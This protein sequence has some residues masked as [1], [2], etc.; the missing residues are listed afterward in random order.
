MVQKEDFSK[1]WAKIVARAWNDPAFKKR[2][3]EKPKEVLESNGITIHA[4]TRVIVNENT[5]DAW[6]LTLP[7]KPLEELSE[8]KLREIAAGHTIHCENGN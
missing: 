5:K 3:K 7:E 6:H 1:K 2:L 4:G 8:E